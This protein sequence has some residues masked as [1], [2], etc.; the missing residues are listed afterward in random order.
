MSQLS[1]CQSGFYCSSLKE[2]RER[3]EERRGRRERGREERRGG[4]RAGKEG[5]RIQEGAAVGKGWKEKRRKKK[6]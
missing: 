1:R 2:R 4:E 3:G 5:G 6:I